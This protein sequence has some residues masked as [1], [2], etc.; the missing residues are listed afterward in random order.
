MIFK[1]E[2]SE[3]ESIRKS[4]NGTLG[5]LQSCLNAKTVKRVVYTSSVASVLYPKGQH[6]TVDESVWTDVDYV[7]SSNVRHGSSYL[8]CKTLTEKKCLEFAQ[9]HGL[10]V[11][12]V[13]PSWISGSF[14]TPN[15]PHSVKGSM[16]M[17]FGM[18]T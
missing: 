14:I 18:S 11:V 12:S 10:D 16:V 5:I 2:E 6:D 8:I 3:E 1:G 13:L 4:I 15:L 17:I 9:K 7:R